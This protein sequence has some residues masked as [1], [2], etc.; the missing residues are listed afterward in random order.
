MTV[1]ALLEEKTPLFSFE[2]F[3]PKTEAGEA[4]LFDT[5]ARMKDLNPGFVSITCGAGGSTKKQ[6]VEWAERVK[7]ESGIEAV[8]H[9]TCL[10]NTRDEL[11]RNIESVKKAG[12][13]NILAL[14]GDIPQND[15]SFSIQKGGCHFAIDLIRIIKQEFPEAC[16][17]GACYPEGHIN[18][19]SRDL[20]MQRL[21]EK[22]DAGID[23]LITQLFFANE[24][25]Y[26][27]VDRAS[28]VGVTQPIVPGIMPVTNLAQVERFTK[29]CGASIPTQLLE[30]LHECRDE[31][32]VL[33]VGVEHA[34]K[35]CRD[36][37]KNGAKGIHF[38]TLNKTPATRLVVQGLS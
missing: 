1:S 7:N 25:Y 18:S 31:T 5:I 6:T 3:P 8:V 28:R 26:E 2:Y 19:K 32:E 20:D 17:L 12:L 38:Y 9:M 34:L 15:P 33:L 27:F 22:C 30:R 37:L 21:K 4:R 11:A 35:Q 10:G 13:K 36:L 14:R 29:M 23:V 24:H 16:V